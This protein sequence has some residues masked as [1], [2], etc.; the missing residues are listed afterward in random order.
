LLKNK[1]QKFIFFLIIIITSNEIY[2]FKS[3]E[4]IQF[5]IKKNNNLNLIIASENRFKSDDI[6]YRQYEIGINYPF[7]FLIE[8]LNLNFNL[9]YAYTK[10]NNDW[11][12]EKRPHIQISKIFSMPNTYIELRTRHEYRLKSDNQETARNRVRIKVT[13]KNKIFNMKPFVSNELYYDFDEKEL[14]TNRLEAGASILLK[15]KTEASFY[16]K[17]VTDLEDSRWEH[18]HSITLSLSF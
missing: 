3:N 16:Y 10:S 7:N 2:A 13:S 14:T 15:N 9:K 17:L 5:T 8:D 6:Y 4:K 12:L 11:S 18:N 1:V